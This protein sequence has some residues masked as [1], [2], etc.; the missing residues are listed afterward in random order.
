MGGL[1]VAPE[2]QFES[3][4]LPLAKGQSLVNVA[5]RFVSGQ[6]V[7]NRQEG[8]SRSID[9]HVLTMESVRRADLDTGNTSSQSH[10]PDP[11]LET[12]IREKLR[13]TYA[14]FTDSERGIQQATETRS[15]DGD[16]P[17][18]QEDNY[19][20]CLFSKPTHAEASATPDKGYQRIALRSPTPTATEPTFLIPRRP[21]SF[22]F[23]GPTTSEQELKFRQAAVSG[24]D[25]LEGVKVRWVCKDLLT[26]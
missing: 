20:F 25:V 9:L 22:Y 10:S 21:D 4:L 8:I 18:F 19:E 14:D 24:E 3:K 16:A 1:N 17:G 6:A 5:N 23:A 13:Q 2:A 26:P 11:E 7:S 12:H 15:P